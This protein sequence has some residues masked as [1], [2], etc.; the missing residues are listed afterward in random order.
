MTTLSG[1]SRGA[2][3][4]V[5]EV[6]SYPSPKIAP[7]AHSEITSLQIIAHKLNGQNFLQWSRSIQMVIHG[8]GKIGYLDGTLPKQSNDDPSYPEW[9]VQNSMVMA[10]LIH[11]M[12]EKISDTYLFY[13]TAKGIWDR[14]HLAYSELENSY[15]MLKLRNRARNLRQGT[16]DVTQYFNSLIKLWQELDLFS[17][18]EWKDPKDAVMF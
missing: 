2:E 10:W 16:Q 11:S 13:S 15:Q 7:I 4:E 1:A 6:T 12:E 18:C 5:T 8:K 9:D 17:T 3:G 14:V